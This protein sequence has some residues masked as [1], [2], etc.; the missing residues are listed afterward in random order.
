[1][2]RYD[3]GDVV[4]LVDEKALRLPPAKGWYA[5]RVELVMVWIIIGFPLSLFLAISAQD[6]G[7]VFLPLLLGCGILL[8]LRLVSF[9]RGFTE[10]YTAGCLALSLQAAIF[11][12]PPLL[13]VVSSLLSMNA[14]SLGLSWILV[15]II[16]IVGIVC[17]LPYLYMKRVTFAYRL[18]PLIVFFAVGSINASFRLDGAP[19]DMYAT[20]TITP[21]VIIAWRMMRFRSDLGSIWDVS[22]LIRPVGDAK[23][24]PT[25][26][27]RQV[28]ALLSLVRSRRE[29]LDEVEDDELGMEGI[30]DAAEPSQLISIKSIDG[31][32]SIS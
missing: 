1:M 13:F 5:Y 32:E 8:C 4:R 7:M 10:Y 23:F 2:R 9:A 6:A 26:I 15:S 3:S 14:G 22:L 30:E 29:Q 20:V 16:M 12:L 27:I 18:L 25:W 31:P 17:S 19:I 21:G 11:I 28:N 24:E